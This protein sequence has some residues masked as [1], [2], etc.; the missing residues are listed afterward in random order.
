MAQLL[1]QLVGHRQHFVASLRQQDNE[2]V[3]PQ[4]CHQVLFAHAVAHPLGHQIEQDIPGFMAEGIVYRLEVIEIDKHHSQW[5][6][7]LLLQQLLESL[8]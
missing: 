5:T 7:R 3:A 4:P 1:V 8:L 2:L 6:R